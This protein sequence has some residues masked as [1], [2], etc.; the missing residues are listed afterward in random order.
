M[1]LF[2]VDSFQLHP[3]PAALCGFGY[4]ANAPSHALSGFTH[5]GQPDAGACRFGDF[6]FIGRKQVCL[7][8]PHDSNAQM[9]SMDPVRGFGNF[10]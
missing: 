8:C 2:M 7:L 6:S 5:N 3:K 10:K 1:D 9:M 4:D